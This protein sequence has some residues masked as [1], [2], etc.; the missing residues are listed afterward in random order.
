MRAPACVDCAHCIW[1]GQQNFCT[2][3]LGRF[4][5]VRGSYH[6]KS[7]LA[8]LERASMRTLLG[9][10]KCGPIGRYFVQRQPPKGPP[11]PPAGK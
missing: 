9:R 6:V 11:P 10:A 7:V 1:N 3:R 4:D 2:R 5:P 8:W